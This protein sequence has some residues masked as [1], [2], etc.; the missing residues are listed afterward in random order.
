MA[1]CRLPLCEV[2]DC[3]LSEKSQQ[4]VIRQ[5]GHLQQTLH[6]QAR[7]QEVT[8]IRRRVTGDRVRKIRKKKSQDNAKTHKVTRVGKIRQVTGIK[9]VTQ[10]TKTSEVTKIAE[11]RGK[12]TKLGKVTQRGEVTKMKIYPVTQD[13]KL[14]GRIRV[15]RIRKEVTNGQMNKMRKIKILKQDNTDAHSLTRTSEE[16]PRVTKPEV[17]SMSP[18]TKPQ[19]RKVNE[20]YYPEAPKHTRPLAKMK[21]CDCVRQAPARVTRMQGVVTEGKAGVGKGNIASTR[22]EQSGRMKMKAVTES[23]SPRQPHQIDGHR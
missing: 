7:S 17:T 15:T 9:P 20:F 12:V 16:R 8:K 23:P 19:M 10:D 4:E 5:L 1:L 18:F 11:K 14:D 3:L 22:Q 21:N 13:P 6:A 2:A